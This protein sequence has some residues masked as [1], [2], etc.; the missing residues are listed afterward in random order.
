MNQIDNNRRKYLGFAGI[1]CGTA[2]LPD[3][4]LAFCSLELE[5]LESQAPHFSEISVSVSS[6]KQDYIMR[7]LYRYER[8]PHLI[9]IV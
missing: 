7:D 9:R 4:S 1:L 2:L 6:V 3:I 5:G 8:A